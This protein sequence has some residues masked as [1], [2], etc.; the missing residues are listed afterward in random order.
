MDG[1][2]EKPEHDKSG[3]FPECMNFLWLIHSAPK[4]GFMRRTLAIFSFMVLLSPFSFSQSERI[5]QST[6]YF[7]FAPGVR[8]PDN[9]GG[10][11]IGGGGNYRS[12]IG[13][14]GGVDLSYLAPWRDKGDGIG[15]L[16]PYLYYSYLKKR[17]KVEPF[18]SGGYTLFFRSGTANGINFGGGVHYWFA[19]KIGLKL[20]FRDDLFLYTS[21]HYHFVSFRI[22]V[23][24]R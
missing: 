21:P 9:M 10:M 6:G 2:I 22:G 1:H 3:M 5:S 17:N 11:G 16:S 24:F 23:A 13:L 12:S 14:G 15:A 7:H 20:E 19:K 4:E 18:L 8:S